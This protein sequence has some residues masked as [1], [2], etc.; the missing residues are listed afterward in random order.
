MDW[1]QLTPG[2]GLVLLLVLA[3]EASNGWTDAPCATSAAVATGVLSS[4]QALRLTAVGNLVGILL[5]LLVGAKVA[6]T[7]GTGIVRPELI[8]INSIG[9]AMI[10]IIV[11]AAIAAWL[12]LPISKTHS[13]LASL[14][15]IGYAQGGFEALMPTSGHLRDSGWVQAGIGVFLAIICG[16]AFSWFLSRVAINSGISEK[17]PERWWEKLQL[18]TVCGVASGHGFN[19]GLKYIGV[20]TLVLFKSGVIQTFHVM[21]PVVVLCAVV[22]GAGTLVGGWRIHRRLNGM[23]NNQ[24]ESDTQKRSFKPFMGVSTELVSAF[25]IWQTGWLGIP[26]STNHGVVSAMAGAKSASGRVHAGSIVRIVW[27]WVVTYVFCF[28]VA[29]SIAS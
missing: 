9:L 17:I 12:G 24:S 7:I 23:V 16:S 3:A 27:G 25:L 4:R 18:F 22:M 6:T 19:D 26:M 2:V 5:A 28:F 1:S 11:W 20:F 8:S 21:P 10:V 14:A 15:G 29:F 13:L